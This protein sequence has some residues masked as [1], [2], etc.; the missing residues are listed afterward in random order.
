MS[1]DDY[2]DRKVRVFIIRQY[3]F[4]KQPMLKTLQWKYYL[5][6]V[7]VQILPVF[8]HFAHLFYNLASVGSHMGYEFFSEF[9]GSVQSISSEFLVSLSTAFMSQ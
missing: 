6:V 1:I 7:V 4:N 9:P 2:H 8:P 3:Q 5:V